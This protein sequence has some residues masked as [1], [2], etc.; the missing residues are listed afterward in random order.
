M[1][2]VAGPLLDRTFFTEEQGPPAADRYS[3]RVG[4]V[5]L[6]GTLTVASSS[7]LVAVIGGDIKD[8][9]V[10]IFDFS[11]AVHLDDSAAM[12]MQRL[13]E[14]ASAARTEVVVCGL[15]GSV[16]RTLRTLD[17][18]RGIAQ[19]RLTGTLD[20]ARTVA[21]ELLNERPAAG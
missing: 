7:K 14:V 17:I 20:E 5:A 1:G 12:V 15:S 6:K 2:A 3:A 10:V 4:L 19:D 18:L 21:S 16:A 11:E 9:E 8:H 13:F